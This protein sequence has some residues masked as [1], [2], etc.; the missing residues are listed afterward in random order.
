M[1]M[2]LRIETASR[3]PGVERNPM[4][5]ELSKSSKFAA[6]DIGSNAVRLLLARVFYDGPQVFLEKESLI[7]IPIRLGEDVFLH[8]SISQSKVE[9]LVKVMQGFRSLID[10]YEP[11]DSMACATSAMREASNAGAIVSLIRENCGIEV[12]VVDGKEEAQIIFAVHRSRVPPTNGSLL[13]IDVGGGSC[14]LT[15]L[16]REQR[17]TYQSFKVGTVRFLERQIDNAEWT[18]LKKWVKNITSEHQPRVAVGS[19]GNINKIFQFSRQKEG[20][21]LSYKRLRHIYHEIERY[22]FEERIRILGLKPDRA[23]VI[24]PACRI[25]LDVLRWS[26]IRKIFVPLIGL[27]DG[28]VQILYEKH[29]STS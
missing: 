19:G 17:T 5:I 12:H 7:R 13:Y 29:L 18:A 21:P 10:A 20:K 1:S 2:A 15:L 16:S 8:E 23:D 3:K 6:I 11:I 22:S 28:L 26:G 24:V 25:Y 14:E 4:H 27:A 9:R